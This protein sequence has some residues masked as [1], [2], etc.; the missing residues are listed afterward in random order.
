MA[1]RQ[2]CE[3]FPVS[4]VFQR[5]RHRFETCK[6]GLSSRRRHSFQEFLGIGHLLGKRRFD[7][8]WAEFA[9]L[10]HRNDDLPRN[11]GFIHLK[12]FDLRA[13]GNVL[14]FDAFFSD[15][16]SGSNWE[17]IENKPA[18]NAVQR[19]SRRMG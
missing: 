11:A 8:A 19:S 16:E 18:L 7:I 1:N 9:F 5:D 4:A 6:D 10:A 13:S 15:V 14:R 17:V 12:S 3:R 2:E